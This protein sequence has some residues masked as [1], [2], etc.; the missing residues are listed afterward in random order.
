MQQPYGFVTK[1]KLVLLT[2]WQD[3]Q[4]R[5]ELLG[6]RTETLF[7]K[8]ADGED[9]ELVFQRTIFLKL[10]FRFFFYTKEKG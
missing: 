6:Q 10:E 2:E 5:D 1:S 8:P 9:G 3:N 7:G 4:L